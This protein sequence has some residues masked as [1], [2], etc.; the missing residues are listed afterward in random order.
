[1]KVNIICGDGDGWIYGK[2]IRELKKHSKNNILVNSKEKADI[3][4]FIPYYEVQNIPGKTTAWFSHRENK[5]PLRS[6]FMSSAAQVDFCIS[7]SKKYAKVLTDGG[8][9]NVAQVMPGV[10][11]SEYTLR[12]ESR[13]NS[14]KL[15]VGFVGRQY[16]SSNRKNPALLGQI[17]R[18]PFVDLRVSGGKIKSEDMPKFYK[19]LDVVISPAIIE[20]GPMCVVE[21]LSQGIPLICYDG[22][23][24]ANEF[25]KGVIRVP[26]GE[27]GLFIKTL[28]SMW[29]SNA[30]IDWWRSNEIMQQMRDQVVEFTWYNFAK[31]HDIIWD[32]L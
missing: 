16:K 10:D 5:E 18:L 8:F 31:Q 6:K 27:T 24:V 32:N 30:H 19:Q 4:Y 28:K 23:G 12:N 22:V 20:G 7:H 21:S 25:D 29:S 2:F 13:K 3:N 9:K 14:D 11:I 26:F 15:I 17:A 1:M